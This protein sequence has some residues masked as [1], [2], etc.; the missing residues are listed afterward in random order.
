MPVPAANELRR[1]LFSAATA[2]ARAGVPIAMVRLEW[3]GTRGKKRLARNPPAEWHRRPLLNAAQVESAIRSGCNAYLYRLPEGVWVLDSDT[4][5]SVAWAA[6]FGPPVTI[7]PR[8][9][10]RLFAG[11]ARAVLPA[12]IPETSSDL[13]VRQ[14][15]GPGSFYDTPAGTVVYRCGPHGLVTDFGSVPPM[16]AELTGQP[17]SNVVPFPTSTN[18]VQDQ[19]PE[20]PSGASAG[21]RSATVQTESTPSVSSSAQPQPIDDFFT[22]SAMTRAQAM[23]RAAAMLDAIRTGPTSGERARSGIRDA[24]LFLGGLLHTHWFTAQQASDQVSAA[25]AVRWGA[26]SDAD[27][28]WISQG[29]AD[30]R[31]PEK[32]LRV[33]PDDPSEAMPGKDGRPARHLRDRLFT[34]DELAARPQAETLIE[35]WLTAGSLGMLYGPGGS[36]KSFVAL[37]MAAS[38][39][40]GSPWHGQPVKTGRVLYIVGEGADG[41][42]ARMAAWRSVHGV[43]RT[44]VDVIHGA[45]NLFGPEGATERAELVELVTHERYALVVVDT[46]NRCTP[47]LEENSSKDTGIVIRHLSALQSTGATVLLVHHTTKDGGTPR[48]SG[49]LIWA[50]DHAFTVEKPKGSNVVTLRN[51]RQKDLPD[52]QEIVFNLVSEGESACLRDAV[53]PARHGDTTLGA[54]RLPDVDAYD[55]FTLAPLGPEIDYYEGPGRDLV[56]K[57]GQM[58]A[59][60]AAAGTT[61]ISRADACAMLGR[62]VKDGAVRRSWDVLWTAGAL[63]PAT[64]SKT[65]IGRCWWVPPGDGRHDELVRRTL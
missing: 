42:H 50:T 33:R 41:M 55:P 51:D 43:A 10:H 27:F 46:Y 56:P 59:Q 2:Y 32:A 52:G 57:L 48:G 35:G 7:T 9:E 65:P 26:A 58:M 63:T 60:R 45:V 54:A 17:L 3:D 6:R 4:A 25:C 31:R 29:L 11:S 8:G 22:P 5:E 14:L 12:G 34:E 20:V 23:Q 37:D 36:A 61:G 62:P 19:V 16:P 40:T 28:T 1:D 47:G 15:Y 38:I 13:A 21:Q 49:S 18:P 39:S 30:G 44:G 24:A 53:R 64:G